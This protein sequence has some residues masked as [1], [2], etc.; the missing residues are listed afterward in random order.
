MPNFRAHF[1][2]LWVSGAKSER[3]AS[4]GGSGDAAGVQ[5]MR[6]LPFHV[7]RNTGVCLAA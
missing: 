4:G 3:S 5:S 2:L 7:L 6:L 1:D